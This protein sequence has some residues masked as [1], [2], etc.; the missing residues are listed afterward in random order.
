M[1]EIKLPK[2]ESWASYQTSLP[3]NIER[4]CYYWGRGY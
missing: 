4:Y 1:R 2:Y 3:A